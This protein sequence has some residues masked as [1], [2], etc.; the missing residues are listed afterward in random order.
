M[1]CAG[2][3]LVYAASVLLEVRAKGRDISRDEILPNIFYL[4]DPGTAINLRFYYE[5]F[6]DLNRFGETE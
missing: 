4:H 6:W 1:A 3:G 5:F 2:G